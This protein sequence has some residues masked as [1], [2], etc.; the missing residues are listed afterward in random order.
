MLY[1]LTGP[2]VPVGVCFRVIPSVAWFI[3]VDG[4]QLNDFISGLVEIPPETSQR[5]TQSD[6]KQALLSA[7]RD[8]K[9]HI[10]V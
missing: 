8:H 5:R 4:G 7:N 10:A 2:Q 6:N 9:T 1:L 3:V